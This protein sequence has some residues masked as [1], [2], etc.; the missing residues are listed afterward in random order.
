MTETITVPFT[1]T[2]L[3]AGPTVTVFTGTD[4]NYVSG[5][6]QARRAALATPLAPVLA[7]PTYAAAACSGSWDVYTSAC[8]CAGVEPT[9]VT[10]DAASGETVTATVS[11]SVV[12]STSSQTETRTASVTAT[13]ETTVTETVTETPAPATTT[14]TE[15]TT[16]TTVA[17]ATAPPVTV[18][19]PR[20]CQATGQAFR[21]SSPDPS[22]STRYMA[23]F[24]EYGVGFAPG[25][26]A[27]AM[28][29]VLDSRGQLELAAPEAPATEVYAVYV[30]TAVTGTVQTRVGLRSAVDSMV[31]AGTVARIQGCIDSAT[32]ALSLRDLVSGKAN[33]ILCGNALYLSHG[34]GSDN[35]NGITY[36][37]P[38]SATA[39]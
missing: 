16:S 15:A 2:D 21:A 23:T 5:G 20:T 29:F 11:T 27:Q 25:S 13:T 33:L 24:A 35:P 31:N 38:M 19:A 18:V 9:T 39:F 37:R 14:A 6:L 7:L 1:S 12:G 8:R 10:V 34:D 28:N 36:C 32:S 26:A 17:Q 4:F 30:P 3:Q 22:G